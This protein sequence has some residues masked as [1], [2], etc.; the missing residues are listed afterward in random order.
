LIDAVHE[1]GYTAA[2]SPA[3]P[4]K[5]A[6]PAPN[7][8]TEP[9]VNDPELTSLRNRLLGAIVLAWSWPWSQVGV[10][11]T[12]TRRVGADATRRGHLQSFRR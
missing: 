12:T 3:P 11:R 8:T 7:T 4:R 10:T 9:E 1:T 6:E 5:P 2:L